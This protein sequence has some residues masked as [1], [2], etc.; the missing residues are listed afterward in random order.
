MPASPGGAARGLAAAAT[1]GPL[2]GLLAGTLVS[3]V[4]IGLFARIEWPW[5]ALGFVAL[6]PWLWA[7]DRVVSLRG[8]ALAG[9]LMSEAYV[10]V[11]FPWLATA[12]QEY[13]GAAWG[14]CLITVVLAA[15]FI[16]PQFVALA[17][18]RRLAATARPIRGLP[19]AALAGVAAYVAADWAMP[20]LMADT[21]GL[22]LYGSRLLRQGADV[23]G[24]LG[25]TLLLL[26]ANECAL[27]L[28]RAVAGPAVG[29]RRTLAPAAGLVL[30]VL[31]PLAY[32]GL[33]VRQVEQAPATE[34]V[35]AGLVQANLSHYDR[36]AARTNAY[37]AVRHIVDTHA[38]LSREALQRAP[39]D[40]LAWPETVY[41]LTFG[42]P[43][44][45]PG[46]EFDARLHQI[47][48]RTGVALVFG[49]YDAENGRNYNAAFF[50]EPTGSG[51]T[52]AN[53]YRKARP[54]PLTEWVPTFLDRDGVRRHLPWLGTW[55]PGPGAQAVSF[56]LRD[57]RELR[58]AP[59]ICYDALVPGLARE[60]VR[61]GA[62][63]ILTLSNDS[64][65]P[66]A[67][68]PRLLLVISA[69]RSVE[70][71][72]PQLRVTNTGMSAVI[73]PTGDITDLLGTGQRG[74]LVGTVEPGGGDSL[75]LRWGNWLGPTSL[76]VTV[77]LL[78]VAFLRRPRSPG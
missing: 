77:L 51:S 7:L 67:N 25:L 57:G 5:I 48:R 62:E 72:R 65:F 61:D 29:R 63:L 37:R 68:A 12:M 22:P 36:A 75:A 53:V 17:L 42:Q 15:P 28:L 32:G 21:L 39:L 69:F 71:R 34:P 55:S 41:P 4:A 27:A 9:L 43:Q 46:A 40:L 13:S 70:T 8:A 59:L 10:L 33:R 1:R 78:G 30:L 3:A 66:Y 56:R 73:T 2:P 64:W 76:A 60:A 74:V 38:A 23:G 54:Y 31:V 19:L 49:A 20:K 18:A 24:V 58:V 6:V 14:W 35:T 26:L 11:L 50:L 52:V 44:G 16:A 45:E 47:V